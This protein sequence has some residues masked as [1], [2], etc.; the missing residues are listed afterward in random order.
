M[1]CWYNSQARWMLCA[2][3][4]KFNV[5]CRNRTWGLMG[6]GGSSSAWASMLVTLL[7]TVTIFLGTESTLRLDLRH[8]R[9][10]VEFASAAAFMIRYVTNWSLPLKIMVSKG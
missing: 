5:C 1:G 9:S 3:L 8:W 7:S 6:F 10:L 2:A 4:W